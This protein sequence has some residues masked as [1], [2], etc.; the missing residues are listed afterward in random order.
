M[1]N[2][3]PSPGWGFRRESSLARGQTSSPRA[4]S[5][6]FHLTVCRRLQSPCALYLVHNGRYPKAAFSLEGSPSTITWRGLATSTLYHCC[7][8]S[9]QVFA[10][11]EMI[12]LEIEKQTL[13]GG[14]HSAEGQVL[15][16]EQLEFSH[17]DWLAKVRSGAWTT[18]RF[19]TQKQQR[20]L[21]SL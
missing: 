7:H 14:N 3:D 19:S 10:K 21:Q 5:T 9:N 2:F 1:S 17:Q 16:A 6:S 15:A 13:D 20:L 8:S 11:D 18:S 4:L 12:E